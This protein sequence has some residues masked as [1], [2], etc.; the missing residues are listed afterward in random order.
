MH[1]N[2]EIKEGLPLPDFE[3]VDIDGKIFSPALFLGRKNLLIYFSRYIGCS[4][5]QMFIVDLI[6]WKKEIEDSQTEVAVISETPEENLKRYR[7]EGLYFSVIPDPQKKI[8]SLFGVNR[9]GRIGFSVLT[10]SLKF[11]FYLPR[12]R[13]VPGGLKGDTFQVPAIFIAD[14]NGIIRYSFVSYDIARHPS[15]EKIIAI[16]KEMSA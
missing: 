7:P 13:F 5:C 9:R 15:T 6:R 11:L 1:D 16:L 12:Y 8:F 4:W 3:A 14:R 2:R 10:R